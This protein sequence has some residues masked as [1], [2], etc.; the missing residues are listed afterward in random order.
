MKYLTIS[1]LPEPVRDQIFRHLFDLNTGRLILPPG[2]A[3]H[4]MA[5]LLAQSPD[6]GPSAR[7]S[8]PLPFGIAEFVYL[9]NAAVKGGRFWTFDRLKIDA[10]F[11]LNDWYAYQKQRSGK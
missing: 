2:T 3:R 8:D 11:P 5:V 10:A 9:P 7:S 4:E 1:E 6:W